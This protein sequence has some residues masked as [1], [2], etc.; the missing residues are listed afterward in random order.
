MNETLKGRAFDER[1]KT[2]EGEAEEPEISRAEA[3]ENLHAGEESLRFDFFQNL[4][5]H[6][7]PLTEFAAAITLFLAGCTTPMRVEEKPRRGV[8]E[9]R[10][11]LT[12]KIE[13]G[14]E[15]MGEEE[16]ERVRLWM[17]QL[18]IAQKLGYE[19]R[20]DPEAQICVKD[21]PD[22]PL[23]SY[24]LDRIEYAQERGL[25]M[26]S[27]PLASLQYRYPDLALKPLE[28][29]KNREIQVPLFLLDARQ[30]GDTV[31]VRLRSW[32]TPD[33][34]VRVVGV[35]PGAVSK[36]KGE[37]QDYERWGT[38]PKLIEAMRAVLNPESLT[39][40]QA[41]LD[42]QLEKLDSP[43]LPTPLFSFSEEQKR[44]P[45]EEETLKAFCAQWDIHVETIPVG[46]AIDRFA[47]IEPGLTLGIM[48]KIP[49]HAKERLLHTPMVTHGH[50]RSI[51]LEQEMS[52]APIPTAALQFATAEGE[53][54]VEHWE[55]GDG[56]HY[57]KYIRC[58][59][60]KDETVPFMRSVLVVPPL[61][62]PGGDDISKVPLRL[63]LQRFGGEIPVWMMR[64]PETVYG[65]EGPYRLFTNMSKDEARVSFP[66]EK[67]RAFAEGV[68][69]VE[70]LFGHPAG[71]IV[72]NIYCP[73]T[74]EKNA[75]SKGETV[76]LF[77]EWIRKEGSLRSL[78]SVGMHEAAHSIDQEYSADAAWQECFVLFSASRGAFLQ[79][80]CEKNFSGDENQGGHAYDN[81]KE[82][83]ASFLNSVCHEAW[84]ERFRAMSDRDSS[85][86][87]YYRETLD[88]LR[89]ALDN[90]R[91]IGD[92]PEDAPIFARIDEVKRMIE[93]FE[94]ERVEKK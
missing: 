50:V 60:I 55:D 10:P 87:E 85:F 49:P 69:A 53:P 34:P 65:T 11:A 33:D 76:I 8:E 39:K 28:F 25:L 23:L 84:A 94:K 54:I 48:H 86:S 17:E 67:V 42:A 89:L 61:A 58:A 1:E 30:S 7:K 15:T 27:D 57:I 40:Y 47:T 77:D 24:I 13:G 90:R 19:I 74:E 46:G 6:K 78:M 41:T 70:E 9:F 66:A 82:F 5:K 80:I 4:Q 32:L 92:I 12:E 56:N 62:L 51:T 52:G 18:K 83:F 44:S 93:D 91:R 75:E 72:R 63:D 2:P 73:N 45:E 36:G 64:A 88:A 3:M 35:I 14:K 68:R 22:N 26:L 37:A 29:S 59:L 21:H 43:E 79:Q 16:R 71:S 20:V 38:V 31:F 81:R